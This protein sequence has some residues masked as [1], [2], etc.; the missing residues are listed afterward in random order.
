[1]TYYIKR[2]LKGIF[3]IYLITT[4][5]FFLISLI[6][7]DPATTILGINANK[8]MIDQFNSNF[9]LDKP[10]LQRYIFWIQKA[11][12][13]EFGISFRYSTS[14]KSIILDRLPI[15]LLITIISLIMI[16]FF[17]IILSIY[18]NKKDNKFLEII[19]SIAIATPSFW[20]ATLAIYLFSIVFKFLGT[21][22]NGTFI[23]LLLPC[24]I[25]SIPK[26]G[27][28]TYNIRHNIYIETRKDYSKFLYSNGLN[29][30]YLLKY[31]LINS[32][33]PILPI[34]GLIV[35]DLLSGI[36]II[37]QIFS[38]PGLGRLMLLSIYNRDIPLIQA[39]II[40]TSFIVIL[41]NTINDIIYYK[42]DKRLQELEFK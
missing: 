26:I 12:K 32:I 15:T 41:I 30:K 16:L 14:V 40:Y 20:I 23:S 35:I 25:I 3:S 22:Y 28:L 6:P 31:I 29:K 4:I 19:L 5:S 24:F 42:F 13:G 17:S 36:L 38:I 27:Q 34:I 7:G 1:M 37:E 8:A 10:I 2:I 9:N 33:L 11:I 18:L 39:L 21:G